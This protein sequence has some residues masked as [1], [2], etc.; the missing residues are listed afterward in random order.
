MCLD[1]VWEPVLRNNQLPIKL[2]QLSAYVADA[3]SAQQVDYIKGSS[4][5]YIVLML[6]IGAKNELGHQVCISGS[7]GSNVPSFITKAY[8]KLFTDCT[9]HS[10][11]P[12]KGTLQ[13]RKYRERVILKGRA[14]A[15]V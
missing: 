1:P 10:G 3:F 11:E 14:I 9:N 13:R 2:L 6:V 15:K 5:P 8:E 4:G 12:L 7:S